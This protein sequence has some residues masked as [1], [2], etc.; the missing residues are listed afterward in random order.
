MGSRAVDDAQLCRLS[1]TIRRTLCT[2]R[3]GGQEK[4]LSFL[5]LLVWLIDWSL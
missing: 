1:R 2:Y 3:G 5:S 4:L